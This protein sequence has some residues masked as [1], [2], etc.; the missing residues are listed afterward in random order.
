M[1]IID[2]SSWGFSSVT[3]ALSYA[4][5]INGHVKFDFSSL[6]GTRQNDFLWVE[7]ITK[8]ALQDDILV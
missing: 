2:L 1:D 3:E 4:T 5:E 6:P 7:N 8:A